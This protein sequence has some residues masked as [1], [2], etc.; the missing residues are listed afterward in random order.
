MKLFIL[1][2]IATSI[3]A[4]STDQKE[5]LNEAYNIGGLIKAKDGMTFEKTLR[6]IALTESSAGKYVV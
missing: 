1:P 3:L 5:I 2:L 4:F 6:S